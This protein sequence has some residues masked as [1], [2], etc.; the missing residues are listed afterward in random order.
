MGAKRKTKCAFY[1]I[2]LKYT[3]K[4]LRLPEFCFISYVC[5]NLMFPYENIS[6]AGYRSSDILESSSV[7]NVTG[8]YFY[9]D[10]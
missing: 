5:F 3:N 6:K 1:A 7:F 8:D 10:Q 2:E 4:C 9:M